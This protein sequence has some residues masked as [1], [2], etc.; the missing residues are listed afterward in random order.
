MIDTKAD[1]R[2][3]LTTGPVL[4]KNHVKAAEVAH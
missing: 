1:P 2:G 4:H 3:G